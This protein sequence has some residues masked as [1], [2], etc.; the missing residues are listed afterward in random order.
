[1]SNEL[2]TKEQTMQIDIPQDLYDRVSKHAALLSGASDADVIR[3]ALD[4]LDW[5]DSER[6]A[7]QTG[8]DAWRS[9]DSQDFGSFDRDFRSNN[10]IA[11]IA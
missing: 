5:L 4:S 9:G 3:K 10:S 8:I 1:M 11:P 6:R 7:I 2:Y